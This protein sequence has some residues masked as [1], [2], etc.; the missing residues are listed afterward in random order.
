MLKKFL[1]KLGISILFFVITF[2]ILTIIDSSVRFASGHDI[3]SYG[4][5][6][7][8]VDLLC[9]LLQSLVFYGLWNDT[10]KTLSNVYKGILSLFALGYV[11]FSCVWMVIFWSDTMAGGPEGSGLF[12]VFIDGP[13]IT[14]MLCGVTLWL[15]WKKR[16]KVLSR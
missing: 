15:I 2:F 13:V 5:T 12:T 14:L 6:M 11:V 7:L 1:I 8:Y 10:L 4:Q 3:N 9:V 16:R